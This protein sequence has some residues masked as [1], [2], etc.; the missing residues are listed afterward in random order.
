MN[1]IENCKM[2]S[3]MSSVTR[4]SMYHLS[5]PESVLEH[6]GYVCLFSVMLGNELKESGEDL[7]IEEIVTKAAMHDIDEIVTGDIPRTTKYFSKEL[8][9]QFARLESLGINEVMENLGYS[10]KDGV[11]E[12]LIF[13]WKFAKDGKSGIVV[14]IA[15]VSAVV[16]KVWTE[17]TLRNGGDLIP[18]ADRL[19]D[20]IENLKMRVVDNMKSTES[21]SILMDL[22]EQMYQ[23][24]NEARIKNEY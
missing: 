10:D 5:Q 17:I 20:T 2:M 22:L 9:E 16:Y 7:S 21:I 23:I 15:D 4:Y 24:T 14:A 3:A 6:T 12:R 8:R 18:V 1:F 19:L 11:L 13:N